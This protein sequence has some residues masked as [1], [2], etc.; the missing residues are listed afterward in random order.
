MN[1]VSIVSRRAIYALAAITMALA[2]ILPAIV[3]AAQVTER[4]IQLSNASVSSTNVTYDVNFTPV[5]GAGAFVVDFCNNTPLIGQECT[6]PTGFTAAGATTATAGFTIDSATANRVVV[7]GSMTASAVSVDISGINNP[8]VAGTIYARIVT[9]DTA[10]N[11]AASTPENLGANAVDNGAVALSITPTIGISG[12]VLE[13]IT[14]CVS[15]ADETE[16]NPIQA[17]C[18]GTLVAPTLKLGEQTGDVIAL[19]PGVISEGTIYTQISTNANSGAV[20]RLKSNA[21]DC[22]GL[23]RAGAAPGT[24]DILPALDQ[25]IT[26]ATTD[27]RFGVKTA[28]AT[29]SVGAGIVP[30][31]TLVPASGSLYS[32]SSYALNYVAGNA[33]GVTS[34]FGDPFLDTAGDPANNQNMALTFG[35]KVN[36]DTPAGAYSADLSMIAVGKF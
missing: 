18:S 14:F 22:G 30:S 15:G 7:A 31:G 29:G 33:T 1:T 10:V 5:S 34:T 20:V 32:N 26:Q 19:A 23:L 11:A 3:S 9:F 13:S 36:N 35:V 12:D 25:D 17:D 8:S 21:V 27:A 6:A 4:S 16:A 28:A 2:I 24:C